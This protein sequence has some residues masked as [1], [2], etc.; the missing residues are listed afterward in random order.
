[1]KKYNFYILIII[2]ILFSVQNSQ[3]QEH[4]SKFSKSSQVEDEL[5]KAK[6]LIGKD[7]QEATN[8]ISK[9]LR[10]SK[11][12]NDKVALMEAYTI[13]GDINENAKL[14]SL[15]LSRYQ[16]A[17]S[18][19]GT[20][21]DRSII[22]NIHYKIG[23]I[24]KLEDSESAKS[25]FRS[26]MNDDYQTSLYFLCYEGLA[27]TLTL[28]DSLSEAM[29]ILTQLELHYS[30]RDSS[31][32]AR[33]Q[34]RKAIVASSQSRHR[35]AELNFY[36]ARSNY[37]RGSGDTEDVEIINYAKEQISLSQNNLDD[38]IE[39]RKSNISEFEV[40]DNSNQIEDQVRLADAYIRQGDLTNASNTI[41]AAKNS[42]TANI[43]VK[44]K[45][46]VFK[47]AS[48]ISALRGEYELALEEY[49]EYENAQQKLINLQQTDLE[50]KIRLLESQKIID[51]DA[52]I[53]D[54]NRRLGKSES[55]LVDFQ[56][57]LIYLL[58]L[59]LLLALLSA[60]WIYKSLRANRIANKKL[61]LKSLSAQMNPHFI[62]NA[63]NSVNEYIATQDE[64]KANKYLT[65]FSKLMRK[66]L[67][68][69]QKDLIPLSE[70]LELTG[71][72]LKLEHSRFE[73]QFDYAF[74]IDPAITN[75]DY[76]IS[77]MLLQPYI[78]NAIWHGLRYKNTKGLLVVNVS[79]EGEQISISIKDNG[80]GREESIKRKTVHQK[81]HK[82]AGMKNT[83]Q[84]MNIIEDL[85][86]TKYS[87]DISEAFPHEEDKGTL[88]EIN[89][90]ATDG[91]A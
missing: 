46:K 37:K 68:V 1:M 18:Y 88:V 35:Y 23:N 87:I 56:K 47:E 78:E 45:S 44:T 50:D 52:N 57:Y 83:A 69:N 65:Q 14:N 31:A 13:L 74:E 66:V 43:N 75:S 86:Q 40:D 67:D 10:K 79:I 51:I 29:I 2:S 82:A 19:T 76:S 48:E 3:G 84:R 16:E 42:V 59:L 15:A 12:A 38:E 58:G 28:E 27:E 70:E 25:A 90:Y 6:A 9:V 7:N 4:K 41:I 91:K 34:S 61:E 64:I 17:L 33:I 81:Q 39:F 62:F 30:A 11:D 21:T 89:L 80:I 71:L 49:K 53:Y 77:P 60:L 26:C 36:N 22:A 72:Y 5:Q 54:S 32:L 55:K 8:I 73:D 85:Y 63:L 24:Y 20:T